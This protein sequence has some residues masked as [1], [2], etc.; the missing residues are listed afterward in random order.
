MV[1]YPNPGKGTRALLGLEE[2]KQLAAALVPTGRGP[3][4]FNPNG[5]EREKGD[6]PETCRRH[7]VNSRSVESGTLATIQ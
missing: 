3:L 5:T 6:Y 4:A 2:R 1:S 7:E